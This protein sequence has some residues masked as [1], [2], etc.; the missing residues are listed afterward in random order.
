MG[1]FGIEAFF[2]AGRIGHMVLAARASI[3]RRGGMRKGVEVGRGTALAR[4]RRMF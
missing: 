4:A 3:K 1:A 2:S